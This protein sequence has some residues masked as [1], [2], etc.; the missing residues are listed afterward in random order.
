MWLEVSL[1]ISKYYSNAI[2][3]NKSHSSESIDSKTMYDLKIH[4]YHTRNS[5]SIQM[6][7]SERVMTV[8]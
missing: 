8:I 6:N 5:S 2:V 3:L 1:E 4:S 7:T